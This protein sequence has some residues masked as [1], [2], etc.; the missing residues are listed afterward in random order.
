M[1]RYRLASL[2]VAV[3]VPDCSFATEPIPAHL[4]T[5]ILTALPAPTALEV[6][7]TSLTVGNIPAGTRLTAFHAVHAASQRITFCIQ[8]IRRPEDDIPISAEPGK[9]LGFV[10]D[11]TGAPGLAATA[12]QGVLSLDQGTPAFVVLVP[13]NE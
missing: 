7:Q 9:C 10:T 12:L 2:I 4:E 3:A 5:A 1:L 13:G 8:T 11:R 6:F